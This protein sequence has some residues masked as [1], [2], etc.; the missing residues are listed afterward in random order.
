MVRTIRMAKIFT[1]LYF[2]LSFHVGYSFIIGI[3]F[4]LTV[5]DVT[6]AKI[7]KFGDAFINKILEFFGKKDNSSTVADGEKL[8]DQNDDF[9][10]MMSA[11]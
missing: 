10:S 11:E 3:T 1:L 4:L 8:F 7:E 6:E 9:L 5:K 2:S